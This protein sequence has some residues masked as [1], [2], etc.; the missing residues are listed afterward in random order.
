M[1][2]Y[3]VDPA[4]VPWKPSE[5]E[6]ITFRGQV[7]LSGSDGGPEALRLRF[8]AC[9]SVY[10]HMHLTSQFQLLLDGSMDFPRDSLQLRPPGVHYTDHNTPYGPFSVGEEHDVLVL[11]PK[12]GGLM[13][14]GNR[15]ARRE[16]NLTGRVLHGMAKDVDW[17]PMPGAEAIRYKVLIPHALGPEAVILECPPHMPLPMESAPYGRYEVVLQGSMLV[18]GRELGACG[19]RYVH[20]DER[21]EPIEAGPG[22]AT[23]I[24]LSFDKDALEG[25]LSGEGIAVEAAE[26]MARA[27]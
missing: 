21:P 20:G 19:L 16:I 23:L 5:T 11:H 26:A 27:I 22:G 8:D 25:G 10:A 9:L 12:Q 15:T 24:L 14:M 7:L 4:S 13:T 1:L 18:E 17:R 2:T 6:G 3:V